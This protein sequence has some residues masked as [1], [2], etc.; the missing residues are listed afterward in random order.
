MIVINLIFKEIV[1]YG[2][3]CLLH[4]YPFLCR[5]TPEGGFYTSLFEFELETIGVMVVVGVMVVMMV[6]TIQRIGS[7][8]T[9][10]VVIEVEVRVETFYTEINKILKKILK[11]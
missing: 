8:M 11:L 4:L 10:V 9:E 1:Y 3:K 2:K 7:G 5:L 6:E